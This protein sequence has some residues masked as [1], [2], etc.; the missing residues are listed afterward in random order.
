MSPYTTLRSPGADN[1]DN[2]NSIATGNGG[3]LTH[4]PAWR[5][6]AIPPIQEC[7]DG[8]NSRFSLTTVVDNSSSIFKSFDQ[9]PAIAEAELEFEKEFLL[10]LQQ[11][12]L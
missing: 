10:F 9:P 3:S 6:A 2:N 8:R 12:K 1:V 5:R 7:W 11:S 4:P